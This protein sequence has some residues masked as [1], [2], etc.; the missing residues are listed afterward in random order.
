MKENKSLRVLTGFAILFVVLGHTGTQSGTIWG[1][2]PFYSFHIPL[3]IMISGYF[4]SPNISIIKSIKHNIIK[5]LIPFYIFNLIFLLLHSLFNYL[6]SSFIFG[7]Q[8]SIYN[9]L[10]L[11][12]ITCQPIGFG[13][14]SWFILMLF[15]T[16]TI[17]CIVY[18]LIRI[19][20]K[21]VKDFGF[22]SIYLLLG[23]IGVYLTNNN[24]INEEWKWVIVRVI[25]V[26]PFYQIGYIYKNYLE[27]RDNTKSIIY[28][29]II[30]LI[31][32]LLFLKRTDLIFGLWGGLSGFKQGAVLFYL[33]AI[34]GAAF[35][36]RISKIIAKRFDCK[37]LLSIG[38]NSLYIMYFHLS[39]FFAVN[40][41]FAE[42][43][44]HIR[45]LSS[46]DLQNYYSN[47]YYL[48]LPDVKMQLIYVVISIVLS[49]SLAQCIKAITNFSKIKVLSIIKK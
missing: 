48:W 38:K 43:H 49:L 33:S 6:N 5:L 17:H 44:K 42:I 16:K 35:W 25:L 23:F 15:L 24:Y 36:L 37:Y 13:V 8:F 46:F 26:L 34:T 22:L 3:F 20:N 28:F 30:F 21:Y 12:W 31:Q 1:W 11:P 10:V 40:T 18:N 47:I 2:F 41:V 45:H 29:S 9:W 19:K 39:G 14:A 32:G 4:F 27:K 7:T